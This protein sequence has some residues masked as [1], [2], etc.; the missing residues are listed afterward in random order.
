MSWVFMC[1][2]AQMLAGFRTV[3]QQNY[4][5]QQEVLIPAILKHGIDFDAC[6][7]KEQ[8]KENRHDIPIDAS[9]RT[10][11]IPVGP[12]SP[13]RFSFGE[14]QTGATRD[15]AGGPVSRNDRFW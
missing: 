15:A 7:P 11:G 8:W 3:L 10:N 1:L 6:C 4:L 14:G 2:A 9:A 12:D 5:S 13:V